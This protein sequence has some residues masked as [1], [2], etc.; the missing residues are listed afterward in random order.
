MFRKVDASQFPPITSWSEYAKSHLTSMK[1]AMHIHPL[2][3]SFGGIMGN[4]PNTSHRVE[5]ARRRAWIRSQIK[6][7][8]DKTRE[9]E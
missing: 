7:S 3:A 2:T 1:L 4:R 5:S 8:I 6:S 9:G